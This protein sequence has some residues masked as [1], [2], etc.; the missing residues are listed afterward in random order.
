MILYGI[1]YKKLA[2]EAIGEC[3]INASFFIVKIIYLKKTEIF[4]I[5][6]V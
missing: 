5:R 1:R 3:T 6:F 4:I 2:D